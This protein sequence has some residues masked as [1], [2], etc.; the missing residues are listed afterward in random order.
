MLESYLCV[1]TRGTCNGEE[2]GTFS[3]KDYDIR[4]AYAAGSVKGVRYFLFMFSHKVQQ[5]AEDIAIVFL[6]VCLSVCLC[7]TP[8]VNIIWCVHSVSANSKQDMPVVLK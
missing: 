2:N 5:N 6:D 4:R 7:A 3:T 8:N 1:V